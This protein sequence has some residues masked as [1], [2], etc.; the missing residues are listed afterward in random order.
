[1]AK[2]RDFMKALGLGSGTFLMSPI[3]LFGNST[4]DEIQKFIANNGK[5][6]KDF[7]IDKDVYHK[8]E[9]KT[10]ILIAGGGMAGICAALAAARNGSKVILM[11]DRSRL[12]GNASCEIR[13]HISGAS[14]LKQVWRE[15]GILEELVLTEAVTNPQRS[16]EMWDYVLYD[17]LVSEENI[18]LLLDTALYD[19]EV[20]DGQIK[21]VW[22]LCS[23]TEEISIITADFFADCT[24]DATLAAKAGAEYMRGREAKSL[25]GESLAVDVADQKTMGNSLL[26][27]SK[28]Y[29]KKM[30]FTP[31]KWARKYTT[32]DFIHRNIQTYEY[33]YWWLELGGEIDIVRDG[34]QNRHDLMSVLF[35]VWDY[36][37]NSGNHPDSENW[38][39]SWVGMIPGKRESRRVVGDYIMKQEDVQGAKLFEDRVAYGGWPLDDHPPGGMDTT[40]EVPY[41]SI[42]LKGPYSIP[43]KT[44]YSKN[45]GNL[46]MAGRNISVSHVALSSTRVM[47]TCATLGQ[48]IGTGMFYCK[49]KNLLPSQLGNDKTHMG[50]LQQILL[51]Q[52]QALLGV[53][54]TDTN[55][56]AKS[57]TV[58]ASSETEDGKAANIL[59][60]INREINDG[61]SHKWCGDMN[62]GKQW[63]E[64][65]WKKPVKI[66]TVQLTFDTGLERFLRLSGQDWVN[67]QQVR[68]PQPETIADYTIEAILSDGK[69]IVV[70]NEF[71]FLR[72]V[73]HR[74]DTLEVKAIKLNIQKT[75]GDPLAKVFEV[76]CYQE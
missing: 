14:Q 58:K 74:F 50:N 43:F 44:L 23:P 11:Q 66:N 64:L 15:T 73:E 10:D 16:Y 13:M 4:E 35:G 63:I 75:H 47:A 52:D 67:D 46:L 26:F 55:D 31:P 29:D 56:L 41:V 7:T 28:K 9:Y 42:P 36:I 68:G 33:G 25:W 34:Q 38:A 76:R 8:K 40:G 18:T 70:E 32:K 69:K 37:K 48:A 71:N 17:K 3:T 24:G 6:P 45:I 62:K 2:R 12:G 59:D 61:K 65:S 21:K 51:R 72:R 30:P 39:L 20:V 53:A 27:M 19:A 5:D 49:H 22:G 1:M 54:N 60:G 57:A